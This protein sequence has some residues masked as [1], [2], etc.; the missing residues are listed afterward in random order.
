MPNGQRGFVVSN[1]ATLL[2]LRRGWVFPHRLF[3]NGEPMTIVKHRTALTLTDVPGPVI[4]LVRGWHHRPW[5]K[6]KRR[7]TR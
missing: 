1:S 3:V 6:T 7:F 5:K 2:T 4:Y